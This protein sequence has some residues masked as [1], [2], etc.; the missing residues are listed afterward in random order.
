MCQ[1]NHLTGNLATSPVPGTIS[2]INHLARLTADAACLST[3]PNL[4]QP[5]RTDLIR[6]Y[7]NESMLLLY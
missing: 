1:I 5:I 4:Q 2:Q 6:S 7:R 3:E